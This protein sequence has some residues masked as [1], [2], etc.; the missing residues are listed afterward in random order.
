[1]PFR[2]P[3]SPASFRALLALAAPLA[4]ASAGCTTAATTTNT[5]TADDSAG[6]ATALLLRPSAFIGHTP[7]GLADGS[8]RS[9][10]ATLVSEETDPATG[11]KY[12]YM[13]SSI[14]VSCSEGVRWDEVVAGKPYW[15]LID[16]YEKLATDI[17]PDG[18]MKSNGTI[19]YAK[20]HSG[21]SHMVNRIGLP[22]A[23]RWTGSCGLGDH[24][25]ILAAASGTTLVLGCDPLKDEDPAKGVTAVEIDPRDALGTLA[26]EG[27]GSGGQATVAAFDVVSDGGFEDQLGEKACSKD[28]TAFVVTKDLVKDEVVSFYVGA[29]ATSGGPL[30]WG[31]TCSAVVEQGITVHAA[32]APLTAEGSLE[33]DFADIL[34]KYDLLCGADFATFDA[35]VT[36]GGQVFEDTGLACDKPHVYK[37]LKPG[38]YTADL[39]V[40][41]KGGAQVFAVTCTGSIEPGRTNVITSCTQQ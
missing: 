31:A 27:E 11:K 13:S 41:T 14:P 30:S 5:T 18:W 35:V 2:F 25:P 23:A 21:S 8:M 34:A 28:E 1:V 22:V 40:T 32:C 24:D 39:A 36:A 6:Y 29:R 7:C 19:N 12:K 17:G 3:S 26:C 10:V 38:D 16:G 4:L 9:Y 33:I 20:L 37:P 15:V